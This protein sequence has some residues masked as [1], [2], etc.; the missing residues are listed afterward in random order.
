MTEAIDRH[1]MARALQLARQ[2]LYTTSPNPRVGCVI[3]KG[4]VVVGEG[5]HERAGEPHAEINALR[6]AGESARDATAYVTL[7]PCSHRGRTGPCSDAL[8]EAGIKRLVVAQTDPNPQV[9]SIDKLGDAGVDVETGLMSEDAEA[10]N[11]GFNK[12]MRDGLPFVRC[13]IASSTDG[14]TAMA[15]GESQWITSEAAR[16]DVQRWRARSCAILTGSGTVIADDPSLNQRYDESGRQPL[17]VVVDSRLRVSPDARC[18]TLAGPSVVATISGHDEK[19]EAMRQHGVDVEN[20]EADDNGQCDLRA[21]LKMLAQREI[22]EVHVEAGPALNG[23]L[24]TAGLIDELLIYQASHIMGGEARGMFNI[25]DLGRMDQRIAL[26]RIELRLVGDDLRQR[27]KVT[28]P[29]L[30][31]S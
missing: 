7:E 9:D 16:Q 31:A 21:V 29:C 10:L 20:V 1:H 15:S 12:R 23:A 27:Y 6:Q 11:P 14:R 18:L 19:A 8:V 4:D 5:W 26:T 13:K 17:R 30:P 25:N 22:N 3:V 24:L 28:G 2:G